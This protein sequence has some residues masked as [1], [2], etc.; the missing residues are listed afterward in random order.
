[1]CAAA[2]TGAAGSLTAMTRRTGC[3]TISGSST[4]R[5]PARIC[6]TIIS[7]TTSS[8]LRRTG[9]WRIRRMEDKG[10]GKTGLFVGM[11]EEEE[12][13][14]LADV[15]VSIRRDQRGRR[16]LQRRADRVAEPQEE[17]EAGDERREDEFK[18]F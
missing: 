15:M 13:A 2:S 6:R 11:T 10:T 3:R 14:F 12:L 9:I 16:A 5:I 18:F 1:M 4:G 17:E 7:G 8:T